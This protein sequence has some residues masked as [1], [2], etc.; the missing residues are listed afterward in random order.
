MEWRP[1]ENRKRI[2]PVELENGTG[3]VRGLGMRVT[4]SIF[5]VRNL[6]LAECKRRGGH[7]DSPLPQKLPSQ[8]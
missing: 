3:G 4:L 2:L 5:R 6:V 8:P 7:P 1:K